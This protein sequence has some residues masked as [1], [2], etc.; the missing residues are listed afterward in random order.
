MPPAGIGRRLP[1]NSLYWQPGSHGVDM[2]LQPASIWQAHIN[3]IYPAAPTVTRTLAFIRD[4]GARAV[5]V[6]VC[7]VQVRCCDEYGVVVSVQGLDAM[8][9]E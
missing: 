8:A 1:F 9:L 3:F 2:F 4:I 6:V 5:V 7:G